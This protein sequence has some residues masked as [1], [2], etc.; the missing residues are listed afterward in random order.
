MGFLLRRKA[1]HAIYIQW[2][3]YEG[4]QYQTRS[5]DLLL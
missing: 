3:W 4:L 2:F 5:K 1:I